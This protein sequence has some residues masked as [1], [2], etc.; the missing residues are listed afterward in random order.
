MSWSWSQKKRICK[1]IHCSSQISLTHCCPAMQ[2]S[3]AQNISQ[4]EN[5]YSGINITI[6]LGDC[7]FENGCSIVLHE[8]IFWWWPLFVKSFMFFSGNLHHRPDIPVTFSE[9]ADR[10]IFLLLFK[11]MSWHHIYT[12]DTYSL[13]PS[14]SGR[15]NIPFQSSSCSRKKIFS[16]PHVRCTWAV[17]RRFHSDR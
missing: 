3:F 15:G 13:L 4:R 6:S 7:L 14:E 1:K 12:V 9:N 8:K 16:N 5:Q 11:T 2:I 10:G 17:N